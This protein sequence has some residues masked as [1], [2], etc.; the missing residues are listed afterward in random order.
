MAE[1]LAALDK[2]HEEVDPILVLEDIL[3]INQERV[4]NLAQNI[5]LKLDVFH[6]L[7]LQ[8]NVFTDAFH[9]VEFVS[10]AMLNKIHLSKGAFTDH[11]T[12]LEVL[13]RGG[14]LVNASVQSLS[15]ASHGLCDF[16]RIRVARRFRIRS[17]ES[18]CGELSA[19]SS[20][21]SRKIS[22]T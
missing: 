5:F 9:G 12:D 11:L 13:Q 16:L 3:H 15:A 14:S 21:L 1:K 7:I 2:L 6:L 10:G 8:D 22:L 20:L 18:I 17:I 19:T 4:V